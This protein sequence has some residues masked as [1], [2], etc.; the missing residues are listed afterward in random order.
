MSDPVS[1][2]Q[3][4][5]GCDF[6]KEGACTLAKLGQKGQVYNFS[7]DYCPDA[8]VQGENATFRA[9]Q[10][11]IGRFGILYNRSNPFDELLRRIAVAKTEKNPQAVV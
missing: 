1:I 11:W 10:I 7:K 6:Y 9:G 5:K 8:Q 3:F 2:E 4:C